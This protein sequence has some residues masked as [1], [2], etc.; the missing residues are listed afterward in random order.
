MEDVIMEDENYSVGFSSDRNKKYRRTMEVS[1]LYFLH[2]TLILSFLIFII[3][4]VLD[5]LQFL[6]GMLVNQQQNIPP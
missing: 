3:R 6:M 5:G 2:R 4:L 1:C